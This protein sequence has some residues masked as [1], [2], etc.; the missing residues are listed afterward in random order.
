M[1]TF[2]FFLACVMLALTLPVS[3]SSQKKMEVSMAYRP[4]DFETL[5]KHIDQISIVSPETWVDDNGIDTTRIPPE[6]LKL[7]KEHSVKVMPQI[8]NRGFVESVVHRILTDPEVRSRTVKVMLDMCKKYGLWGMQIDFENVHITDKDALTHFYREAADALHKDGYKISI[9]AVHRAEE[10][11]GPNSYTRWMMENWRGAYDLKALGE[12][13]DYI[14]IMS[15]AQ[16]TRRTTPGPSQGLPWMEAVLQYFM[17]YVPPEKLSLGITTS[18]LHF[19]TEADTARYYFNARSLM[20]GISLKA[21]DSLIKVCNGDPLKWDDKQKV[22]FG[23]IE[24]GGVFEWFYVDNDVRSFDAKLDLVKKYKLR[25]INNWFSE[26]DD[27]RIWDSIRN[28]SW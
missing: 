13:G 3:S 26:Q 12:I 20:A 18:G 23:Y 24:R 6:V 17:K 16:H 11:A 2:K 9:A 19:F 4:R 28:F 14:K 22:L 27:P 10:S 1:K 8:K 25:G 15:Y 21:I 7:A 5:V